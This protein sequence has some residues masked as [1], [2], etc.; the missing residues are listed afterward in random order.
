MT[1]YSG[2]AW[3][4]VK[5]YVDNPNLSW[6]D[7]YSLLDAH[8]VKETTFLIETVRELAERLAFYEKP[9]PP[10]VTKEMIEFLEHKIPGIIPGKRNACDSKGHGP[11]QQFT[12][13]CMDCWRS[14]YETDTEYYQYLQEKHGKN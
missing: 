3:I 11:T 8:H 9:K 13:V 2:Y 7:R 14:V 6:E 5:K 12:E 4:K 10:P 1:D